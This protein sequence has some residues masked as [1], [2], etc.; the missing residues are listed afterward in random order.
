MLM[1]LVVA[2][3]GYV[4]GG[5]AAGLLY[6]AVFVALES[7]FA[8]LGDEF[9]A[10]QGLTAWLVHFTAL[11]PAL[12]GI[13]LGRNPSGFLGDAF[14]QCAVTIR[15]AKPVFFV[16][17]AR[18]GARVVPRVPARSINNWTFAIFT[19]A[20]LLVLPRIAAAVYPATRLR[21]APSEGIGDDPTPI[22]LIGIDRPF[23]AADLREID[24][25]I[26][27]AVVSTVTS[28]SCTRDGREPARHRAGH[29][30]VRRE[31]RALRRRRRR[32]AGER[33]PG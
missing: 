24:R 8:K 21:P 30:E 28:R 4:S 16:G 3:A 29:R 23:T 31:P 17:I 14:Q 1:L 15:K 18:R 7:I 25:G 10:I 12:I 5:F 13:A 27:L 11:L 20:L 19:F 22:E 32:A 2:G 26:G 6:G 9:T 33:S